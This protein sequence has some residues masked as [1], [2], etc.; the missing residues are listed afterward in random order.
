[1]L[2]NMAT[3]TISKKVTKGEDLVVISRKEYERLLAY[4]IPNA[5]KPIRTFKPTASEKKA[6]VAARKRLAKGD[7]ITLQGLH[8]EL[9]RNR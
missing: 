7:Y 9:A 3:G 1:M 6:I 8:H 2:E 4:R 5:S